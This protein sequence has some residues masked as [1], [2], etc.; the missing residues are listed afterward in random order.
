M[1]ILGIIAGLVAL[2]TGGFLYTR[3]LAAPESTDRANE[4][5]ADLTWRSH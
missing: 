1:T 2:I 5:T 3:V 4:I